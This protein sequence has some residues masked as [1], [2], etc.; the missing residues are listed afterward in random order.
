MTPRPN[1]FSAAFRPAG[2]ATERGV[3]RQPWTLL[4]VL[5][6]STGSTGM[7]KADPAGTMSEE[8]LQPGIYPAAPMPEAFAVPAEPGHPPFDIDWSVG[9]RGTV[10]RSSEGDS[11]VTSV[12][13]RFTATHDGQRADIVIEGDADV[14]RPWEPE[15]DIA[16]RSLRLSIS[17][18]APIDSLTSVT[19]DGS[20][21]LDRELASDPA[22]DP[23]IIVPPEVVTGAVGLGIERSFGR[24]NLSWAGDAQRM[25]YGET[26]RRDTGA[27]DNSDQNVWALDTSLRLGF[28]ATPI[29]EVFTEASS[30]RDIFDEPSD[31]GLRSDA[32]SYA[33]RGG[34]AADWRGV[35][36]A[37]ASLGVG[38]HDFD[39]DG[40]E[41]VS[42][43]LYD[44]S[45]TFTPDPTIDITARLRSSVDPVGA[46]ADGSARITRIADA[47]LAYIVNSRLRLRA[48][49]D[50]RYA[51]FTQSPETEWAYGVGS[52]A[53][54]RFNSRAA[55]SADYGFEHR[56][57]SIDGTL[58]VHTI[59]LGV[60]LQR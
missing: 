14:V 34:V 29:F 22:L 23:I 44:A 36:A 7:A 19:A 1:G 56:D 17:A 18:V 37:S 4:L 47:E 20:I 40:I 45:L 26:E 15:D 43:Q 38:Y 53:D 54:L 48:S 16:L 9:L 58:D 25:A 52:G 57:N 39:Q 10:T 3:I 6:A 33:L 46:D 32:T 41:D 31:L 5:V 42:T 51:D 55:L 50:W 35:L 59:G 28:Q 30:G 12:N 49:A 11:F 27:T 8:R 60:T 21:T 2:P 24:F 13:P